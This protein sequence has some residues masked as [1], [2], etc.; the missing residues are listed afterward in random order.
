MDPITGAL[1]AA[2]LSA[3]GSIGGGYLASKG[4]QESKLQKTQRR[5]IDEILAGLRG[6]GQYADLFSVDEEGFQRSFVDPAKHR[7]NNEIA[8]QIQQQYIA[9]G[10]QGGT[11]SQDALTRA[12]VDMD[13]LLNQAYMDYVNN[14][15]NRQSGAINSILGAGSGAPPQQ[16]SGQAFGQAT[17]GY[18]ASD[19]FSKG[20]DRIFDKWPA[21]DGVNPREGFKTP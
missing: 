6:E 14:T 11:G 12:G 1:L 20:V 7:F 15:Q 2:G 5:T 21:S 3:A 19:A 16:S 9:S 8:P 4:N 10:M 17:G 13:M 18:L